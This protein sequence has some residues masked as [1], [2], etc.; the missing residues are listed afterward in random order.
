MCFKCMLP[1]PASPVLSLPMEEQTFHPCPLP[2]LSGFVL[3][4]LQKYSLNTPP[5][6]V[7]PPRFPTADVSGICAILQT[8]LSY[9]VP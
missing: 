5:S 9:P 6:S 7:A 8:R 4:L 3:N 1:G 2:V